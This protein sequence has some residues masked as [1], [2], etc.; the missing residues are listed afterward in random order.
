MHEHKTHSDTHLGRVTSN[1]TFNQFLYKFAE[2]FIFLSLLIAHK[3]DG[4]KF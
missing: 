1:N 2:S 3:P 4:N